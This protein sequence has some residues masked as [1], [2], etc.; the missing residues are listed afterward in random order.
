MKVIFKKKLEIFFG[1]LNPSSW[2]PA[3]HLLY[4]Q[5][6][7]KPTIYQ[8]AHFIG[9]CGCKHPYAELTS[10]PLLLPSIHPL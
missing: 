3:I 7:K 5:K 1:Y 2:F 4:K 9:I 8:E 10:L 6:P